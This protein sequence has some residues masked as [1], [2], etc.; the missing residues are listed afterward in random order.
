MLVGLDAATAKPASMRRREPVRGNEA[1]WEGGYGDGDLTARTWLK[2]P[3]FP[4]DC[5]ISSSIADRRQDAGWVFT[6]RF[7]VVTVRPY[8]FIKFG[9][10]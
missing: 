3:G 8:F 9:H 6:D 1:C 10:G 7:Q 4:L 2:L 5:G